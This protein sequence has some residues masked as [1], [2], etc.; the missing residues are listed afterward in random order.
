MAKS[1]W[2]VAMVGAL[3]MV[4]TEMIKTLEMRNSPVAELV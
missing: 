3:G 1:K 4:G 2:N